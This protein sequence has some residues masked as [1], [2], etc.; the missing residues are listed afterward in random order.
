M[1]EKAEKTHAFLISP[2]RKLAMRIERQKR[3]IAVER[4]TTI[5]CDDF[6]YGIYLPFPDAN[7]CIKVFHGCQCWVILKSVF[8]RSSHKGVWE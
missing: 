4:H 1:A 7:H 2:V 5:H 8:M 6:L 3:A